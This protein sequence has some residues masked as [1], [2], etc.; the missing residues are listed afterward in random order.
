MC[1]YVRCAEVASYTFGLNEEAISFNSE[2]SH[3]PLA[4]TKKDTE[5]KSTSRALLNVC[6]G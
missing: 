1:R 6:M 5:A 4:S 3:S 2:S